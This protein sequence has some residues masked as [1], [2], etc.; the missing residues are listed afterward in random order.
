MDK[1]LHDCAQR[2]ERV[3]V[4]QPMPRSTTAAHPAG[5][6]NHYSSMVYG[7]SLRIPGTQTNGTVAHLPLF[8]PPTVFTPLLKAAR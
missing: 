7:P 3:M 5:S 6:T 8:S 4:S 1:V 2:Y